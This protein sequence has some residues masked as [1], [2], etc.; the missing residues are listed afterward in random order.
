MN[1]ENGLCEF[2]KYWKMKNEI[3]KTR[4]HFKPR[5]KTLKLKTIFDNS[6]RN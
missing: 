2:S 1:I 6:K 3:G 5:K 4:L